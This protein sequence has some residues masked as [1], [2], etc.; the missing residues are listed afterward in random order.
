MRV[1][2]FGISSQRGG[3]ESFLITYCLELKREYPDMEFDFV[4]YNSIPEFAAPLKGIGA[5]FIVLPDRLHHPVKNI[6]A[7]ERLFNTRNY[8]FLWFNVCSLSD[9][10]LL[11]IAHHHKVKT[12]VH[13][14]NSKNMGNVLNGILH[15]W[16][17]RKISELADYCMACS[18]DSGRFMYPEEVLR[19]RNYLEVKNGIDGRAFRFSETDRACVRDMLGIGNK[20]VIG[21]VG[22]FHRQKNHHFLIDVFAELKEK[23]PD[24][25]LMLVGDGP[26]KGEICKY[27]AELGLSDSVIFVG[28]VEDTSPYYSAMDFFL[29]P[30]L[31]EGFVLA[32]IEAQ[33]SGLPCLVSDNSPS[34]L[35]V[36]GRAQRT[37]LKKNASEWASEVVDMLS[38]NDSSRLIGVKDVEKAGLTVERSVK[39]ISAFVRDGCDI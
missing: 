37:S 21:H 9:I 5:R 29:L 16:H 11:K 35:L 20:T 39:S 17:R 18:E 6:L 28:E 1:L 2:V 23:K 15:F 27:V 12:I 26:L 7:S 38:A 36:S 8:H 32:A 4:V 34:E 19:E 10:T 13:A 22:R 14:H 3:V 30:S 24:C 33:C 25:V 31:Y